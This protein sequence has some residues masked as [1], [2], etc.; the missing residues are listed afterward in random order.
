MRPFDAWPNAADGEGRYWAIGLHSGA[1]PF[2]RFTAFLYLAIVAAEAQSLVIAAF[3]PIFVAA[4]ALAAF[5]NGFWMAVQGF[6]IKCAPSL[7]F[8]G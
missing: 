6:F 2:W 1:V 4:L 3:V 5:M 7:C 8:A